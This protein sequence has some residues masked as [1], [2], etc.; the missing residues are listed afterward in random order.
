MPRCDLNAAAADSPLSPP[1]TS[2]NVLMFYEFQPT[3]EPL[4]LLPD[5]AAGGAPEEAA[6]AASAPCRV[7]VL[8][9][10][11]TR[12]ATGRPHFMW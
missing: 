5:E 9:V 12:L 4:L 10:H 7:A 3:P 8:L 6:A 11:T 2:C 1:Q